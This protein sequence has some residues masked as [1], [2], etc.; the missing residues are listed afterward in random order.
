[1]TLDIARPSGVSWTIRKQAE[2]SRLQ[3]AV[4][5]F[6]QVSELLHDLGRVVLQR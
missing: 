3:S 1:M 5:D 6:L 4:L 2:V